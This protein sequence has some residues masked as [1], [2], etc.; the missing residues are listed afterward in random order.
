MTRNTWLIG[1]IAGSFLFLSVETHA[2]SVADFY[3]GKTI[4]LIIG[5][6][7]GSATDLY[8]RTLSRHMGRHIPGN[9][10]LVPQNMPGAGS[11]K[12]ATYFY[13][14]AAKDGLVLG[15]FA[16]SA[17]CEPLLG[18][19][20]ANF[21]STKFG[22]I[23]NMD[24]SVATCTVSGKS[25]ITHF[26]DLM[27]KETL[28]GATSAASVTAQ[29]AVA[30]RNMT[31]AKIKVITGYHGANDI[32]LAMER[33]EVAGQCAVSLSLIKT[34]LVEDI[35]AGRIRPII[36]LGSKK[37]PDLP[38]VADIYDYAKN[39]QDR[40]IFDLIFGRQELGR[41]VLAPPNLPSD[42]LQA[43]RAAFMT[44]MKDPIFL[45]DAKKMKMD[46]DPSSG[47]EVEQMLTRFY[48]YPKAIVDKAEEVT[49]L[50]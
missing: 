37:S 20:A 36:Q 31:G 18:N 43:L 6:W 16:S 28:F 7:A 13:N 42:R 30:L 38:G 29:F 35:K 3:H 21:D 41:P 19:K 11:L 33:G 4:N 39:E 10:T 22:W 24:E 9:P 44:T 25:G 46:I 1:V 50:Q 40:Q 49:R 45:T 34:Q 2:D 14:V 15:T 12:A 26:D 48:S 27:N 17:I 47:D 23:G 8:A 32:P 5:N